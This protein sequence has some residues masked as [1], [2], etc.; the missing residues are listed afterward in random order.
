[1]LFDLLNHSG[2]LGVHFFDSSF[3]LSTL[4]FT[5]ALGLDDSVA[6]IDV[7]SFSVR[8]SVVSLHVSS[9]PHSLLSS[10]AV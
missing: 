7:I 3:V 2:Y 1:M 6:G 8:V 9:S 10:G 4:A 5:S